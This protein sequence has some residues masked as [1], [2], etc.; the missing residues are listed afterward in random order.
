MIQYC[1]FVHASTHIAA[2]V[3]ASRKIIEVHVD[4]TAIGNRCL[5]VDLE[6]L[7]DGVRHQGKSLAE[8]IDETERELVVMTEVPTKKIPGVFVDSSSSVNRGALPRQPLRGCW[9]SANSNRWLAAAATLPTNPVHSTGACGVGAALLARWFGLNHI[10]EDSQGRVH[11]VTV[12]HRQPL[13][14][15]VEATSFLRGCLLDAH[16]AEGCKQLWL[17]REARGH[18]VAEMAGGV[19]CEL[20]GRISGFH[21]PAGSRRQDCAPLSGLCQVHGGIDSALVATNKNEIITGNLR[22]GAHLRVVQ[23]V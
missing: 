16:H 4:R 17:W 20:G 19:G 6:S 11:W 21:A 5:G 2:R 10:R 14:M 15:D 7:A 12:L 22:P 3:L 9:S 18:D 1:S 13:G 23:A 8:L